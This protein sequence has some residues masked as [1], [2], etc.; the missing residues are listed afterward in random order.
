MGT[1]VNLGNH[2]ETFAAQMVQ[3]GRYNNTSELVREGLRI[4]EERE[5][6]L[7]ALDTTLEL[8][9]ADVKAGRAKPAEDVFDRLEAKYTKM[10]QERGE[11]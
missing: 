11:P 7:A 5:R 10:A 6:R 1:T 2:F 9:R 3:S 8:S 4:I